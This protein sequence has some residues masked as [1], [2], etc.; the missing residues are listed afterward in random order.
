[1]LYIPSLVVI[2]MKKRK[3]IINKPLTYFLPL[4]TLVI[5]GLLYFFSIS[6]DPSSNYKWNG[7][8][9]EIKDTVLL[10]KEYGGITSGSVGNS[11]K[12][13][14]QWYRRHWFMKQVKEKELLKLMEYPNGTVKAIVFESLIRKGQQDNY[15][16]IVKALNDTS[17]FLNYQSGCLGETI[18]IGEYIVQNVLYIDQKSPPPP[19]EFQIKNRL[20]GQEIKSIQLIFNERISKK[21][22]YLKNSNYYN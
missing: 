8:R 22:Y 3:R 14:Q 4:G 10:I 5:V 15:K 19:P 6:Y 11:G 12:T 16:L 21:S 18:M 20:T 13:P 1:M 7:I 9:P 17:H 2:T